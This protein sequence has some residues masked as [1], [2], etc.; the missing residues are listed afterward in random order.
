MA[1]C[2]NMIDSRFVD[3]ALLQ[4]RYKLVTVL[5]AVLLPLAVYAESPCST[6]DRLTSIRE[7]ILV[8]GPRLSS[9]GRTSG[10]DS[11]I[12][13]AKQIATI[14]GVTSIMLADFEGMCV[15]REMITDP[16]KAKKADDLLRSFAKTQANLNSFQLQIDQWMA[17]LRSPFLISL[18]Q[19][20]A[21]EIRNQAQWFRSASGE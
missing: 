1:H 21:T 4:A 6:I 10:L 18:S 2:M 3:R 7:R 12:E 14:A 20:L 8:D 9:A 17:R 15:L 16:A 13:G 5:V 11:D 19:S